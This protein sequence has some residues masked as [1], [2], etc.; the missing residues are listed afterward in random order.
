MR[1]AAFAAAPPVAGAGHDRLDEYGPGLAFLATV[2]SE[3]ATRV[4]PVAGD[5]GEGLWVLLDRALHAAY[6]P[7]PSW[8][9]VYTRWQVS[10]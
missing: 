10:Q 6:G 1:W 7:R 2:R 9:P 4:H 3:G 5:L 8:P